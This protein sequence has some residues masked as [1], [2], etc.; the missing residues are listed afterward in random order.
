MA[1][2]RLP[3]DHYLM[4]R[5]KSAGFESGGRDTSDEIGTGWQKRS[6]LSMVRRHAGYSEHLLNRLRAKSDHG[7]RSRLYI[8][9]AHRHVSAKLVATGCCGGCGGR[10]A[11]ADCLL[12]LSQDCCV[13][14]RSA[15]T[16]PEIE[17]GRKISTIQSPIFIVRNCQINSRTTQICFSF[18]F[19]QTY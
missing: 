14:S 2:S 1:G 13:L 18:S 15:L 12:R 19:K 3:P 8:N 4:D 17:T 9:T 7:H 5:L 10:R 6:T 11:S 16:W